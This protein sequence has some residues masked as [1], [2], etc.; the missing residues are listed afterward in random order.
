MDQISLINTKIT[1]LRAIMVV[2]SYGSPKGKLMV[3]VMFHVNMKAA[4]GTFQKILKFYFHE[5]TK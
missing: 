4:S 3:N 1:F 5:A 2:V